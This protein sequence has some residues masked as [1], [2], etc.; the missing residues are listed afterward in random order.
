[1]I[2]KEQLSSSQLNDS[3]IMACM[4]RKE[5]KE[6]KGQQVEDSKEASKEKTGRKRKK[7]QQ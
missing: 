7:G 3:K 6:R 1:M 2:D 4:R 5:M